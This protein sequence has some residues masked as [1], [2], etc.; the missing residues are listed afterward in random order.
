MVLVSDVMFWCKDEWCEW[1][2]AV[3]LGEWCDAVVL[4][5][6]RMGCCSVGPVM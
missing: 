6:W 3:V 1:Y 2:D 5:E 4:G